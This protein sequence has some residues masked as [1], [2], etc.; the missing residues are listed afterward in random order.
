LRGKIW[1]SRQ[2]R[3]VA[4]CV[5]V[6]SLAC[7][8]LVLPALI[9]FGVHWN[10]MRAP[11]DLA[12]TG[13]RLPQL[14]PMDAV[15][16]SLY[17]AGAAVV[18]GTLAIAL[19]PSGFGSRMGR[20]GIA[21]SVIGAALSLLVGP[22]NRPH[23]AVIKAVCLSNV[24]NIT[25]AIQMYAQD[26]DGVLPRADAWCDQL[27]G[28]VKN[29][30]VFLCDKSWGTPSAYSYNDALDRASLKSVRDPASLIA[31]F[32][33]SAGWNA[34][35]G[36][37]LLVKDP[38]HLRGDNYGFADGHAAWVSRATIKEGAGAACRWSR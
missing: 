5:G 4:A 17:W 3:I 14:D 29:R 21:V 30:H 8:L 34:H 31:I 12:R 13:Y 25:L 36:Q 10:H 32:E 15:N 9:W 11:S 37:G 22:F 38:R 16:F 23:E 26:S 35:G 27:D 2:T 24:K 18:L 19:S 20:S 6:V 33:S 1:D 7:G 28:Y